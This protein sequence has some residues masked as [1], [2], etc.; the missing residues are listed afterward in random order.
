ERG[1][2][3]LVV[4]GGLGLVVRRACRGLRLLRGAEDL[5]L[6]VQAAADTGASEPGEVERGVTR[7]VVVGAE[8]RV[9]AVADVRGERAG[10][11]ETAGRGD[12]ELA[13]RSQR[14]G[15]DDR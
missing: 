2:E 14:L 11:D 10:G 4:V 8:A 15:A 7:R 6:V 3:V 1:V 13:A 9:C 12:L 5:R